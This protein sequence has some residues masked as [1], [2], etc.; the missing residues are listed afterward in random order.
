[1]QILWFII[2]MIAYGFIIGMVIGIGAFSY[3][4]ISIHYGERRRGEKMR[5][6]ISAH[7]KP[8]HRST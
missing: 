4:F 1:M 5:K 2:T 7:L 3:A 6:V 8:M